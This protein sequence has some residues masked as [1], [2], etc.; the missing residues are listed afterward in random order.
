M[1]PAIDY[2][3]FIATWNSFETLKDET[4]KQ[5]NVYLPNMELMTVDEFLPL[6]EKE[7]TQLDTITGERPNVWVYIHGPAHHDALTA[8]REASKLLPAAEKFLSIANIIDPVKMQYPFKAFDEAWQAKIYPD[9]GWGGH[10]GD[11]TDNLFKENLV[12]SKT[13][14]QNLLNKGLDFIAGRIQTNEKL[15]IPIVLFNSLSWERTDPVTVSINF[16]K[17][18]TQHYTLLTADQQEVPAQSSNTEYYEDGSLK[19]T[20]ISFVAKKIPSIGYATYYVANAN[21]QLKGAYQSAT[22]SS[23]ENPFYRIRFENGGIAQVHDKEFKKDLFATEHFKV[24]EVFTMQSIGNG[25]GEFGDVQQPS[26]KD[27]DQ[28][29]LH[30][31]E[32]EIME[33]GPVYTKYRLEQKI[34]HAIIRQEVTLYH[35]LKRIYFNTSLRNWSGNYLPGV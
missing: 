20:D 30:R 12:K 11:I 24:G 33:N 10:D 21:N 2:S 4:G 23:Y 13:M 27:F 14:G 19:S 6:A 22:K 1:L 32:W 31:P 16:P 5:K 34:M 18:S 25:A 9:H 29:S 3:E 8:S 17:G 26:M 15:G 35:D 7:A 28:V